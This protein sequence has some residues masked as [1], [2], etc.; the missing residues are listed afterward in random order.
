MNRRHFLH[1]TA[2]TGSA[3][4]FGFSMLGTTE[5][6]SSGILAKQNFT[7]NAWLRI[8]QSGSI[9]VLIHKTEIGQ[10]TS[11]GLAMIVAEELDADW[12]RVTVETIKPDGKRFLITGGSWSIA[13]SWMG[14]R[15]A[16][17]AA[18]EMLVRAAAAQWGV[19]A[20]SCRTER[21][22]VIHDASARRLSYGELAESASRLDSPVNPTLKDP[23]N[24]TLIGKSVDA[25]NISSIVGGTSKYGLD[26]RVPNMLFAVIERSPVINGRIARVDDREAR[27][28][29]G[30]KHIVK[31]RGNTFPAYNYIRD[32]VA[33]VATSTWSAMKARKQLRVS[34]HESW[35]KGEVKNGARA[36]TTILHEEFSLA[37]GLPSTNKQLI[38]PKPT[39]A[40]PVVARHIGTT[41][42]MK[43][44]FSQAA[45]TLDAVY[46]VPLQAHAPLE[47]MNTTAHWTQDSCEIWTPCHFQS[48]LLEAVKELTGLPTEKITIHT[49]MVGGSFGRRLDVDYAIEAVLLSREIQAPV[50][51]IWTREDDMKY[52]LYAP[53]TLHHVRAALDTNG[54]ITALDH[55]FA[56]LSVWK[57]SEP[58]MIEP[59]GLD[60]AVSVDAIKFPYA[61]PNL[62]IKHHIVEHPIRVLWWRR[63]YTPNHVFVNETLIDECAHLARKD[64]LAYRLQ[65]L[66]SDKTLEF[67]DKGDTIRMD[68]ARLSAVLRVAAERSDWA[69]PLLTGWGR[70]I[71]CTMTDTYVGQAVE[72]SVKNS[73]LKIERVITAVDCGVV[74]NPQLVHA[75][76]EGS[77][78]FALTAA[79]KKAITV[80]NGRVQ[81]SNFDDYPI[82]R[83]NEVPIIETILIPST[84]APTGTG[85]PISHCVAAALS[86]AIF[87]ATG[88]RLRSLPFD[89]KAL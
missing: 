64:P 11:T 59:S 83:I 32:G 18:R 25:K 85:E 26:V 19:D 42:S 36:G 86:N 52:G 87:S 23:K 39:P 13:G 37:L 61:T 28:T 34:W 78:V 75:Q 17:A 56:A 63:G 3:F 74:V 76:V 1:T 80:E 24:F 22:T 67:P 81:Q 31:L 45:L 44:A 88:K 89:L 15:T 43:Q 70:G 16:G 69:R 48:R 12:S 57:Q 21:S 30:V 38:D 55:D 20:S 54:N 73:T 27:K 62:I 49:T 65:L 60:Y 14:C 82:L 8:E 33:V 58:E 50:Q 71:S 35:T 2:F 84:E 66:G 9:T 41:D 53:P 68:T 51:V 72:V 77:I 79:L 6:V 40:P 29:K 4:L 7:P 47:P 46:N 10:G 5:A